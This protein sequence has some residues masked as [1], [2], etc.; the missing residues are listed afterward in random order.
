MAQRVQRGRP[1]GDG[2]RVG[3]SDSQLI[4]FQ[5]RSQLVIDVSIGDRIAATIQPE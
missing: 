5:T 1:P 3:K 4:S 2:G